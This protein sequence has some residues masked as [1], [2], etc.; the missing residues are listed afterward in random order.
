MLRAQREKNQRM[1][2]GEAQKLFIHP[3]EAP[4]NNSIA[5]V[6]REEQ[7]LALRENSAAH[8]RAQKTWLRYRMAD[9]LQQLL[10]SCE[11][12]HQLDRN[13]AATALG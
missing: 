3:A 12:C 2:S 11:N 10:V 13:S 8:Q 7:D 4:E 5:R 6:C 9:N 1:P